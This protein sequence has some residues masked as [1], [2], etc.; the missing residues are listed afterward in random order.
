MSLEKHL[1]QQGRDV[2]VSALTCAVRA[3]GHIV[4]VKPSD[5]DYDF[6]LDQFRESIELEE[7]GILKNPSEVW[8]Y[9]MVDAELLIQQMVEQ[10][11]DIGI[12]LGGFEREWRIVDEKGL[13]KSLNGPDEVVLHCRIL[14]GPLNGPFTIAHAVHV[15]KVDDRHVKFLSD[16]DQEVV[17]VGKSNYFITLFRRKNGKGDNR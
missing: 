15:G 4:G 3:L 7:R 14:P 11:T 1:L 5:R 10:N 16:K 8:S 17:E 6:R 13:I 9:D 12:A 2:A